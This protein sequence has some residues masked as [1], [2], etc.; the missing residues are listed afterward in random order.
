MSNELS[1]RIANLSPEK[2]AELLKKMAAQKAVAGN[3]AQG[4]IP[5]QDRSRPLPLSFAQQRL[6]FIDQLQPGT[7]L[8]NVPMAVRLE[9]A[10]DV[11]V[12]ERALRE[13]VRRHEVLRTTF[14]EDASGPVQVV[15]PEPV[16][17]LEHKDL[18]GSA[19]E[20]A[21][22]L[23][24][25][26]AA[27]PFD[28]AKG[29]LLRALLLTSAP[30]EHLLVVVVHH[31]ISDGWSMTLLVREVALLYGAFARGQAA[32]LPPLGIQYA[33]FGV[34][35]REWMQGPRLEKQLDYWKRQLAG[36]PSALELPTDFPRPANRDGRGAR[37]DVLLPRELTDALKALAQQEGASLY[38][39]LLTGWQVL[40]AR[41]SGQDDVTVGSPMAGR[42]RGEVEGLIGLFVN[43]QVLR[44]R[45]TGTASFRTL[46][47]Q[48]RETVLGAQ[49]HQELPIERLVEEVKPERIPGRTPFFQV[50]LTYQASF[51]GAAT[52]EGVKLEALELD[53]FSAKFDLTLQVLETDAG[54]KGY[55]EY[56][57][58]LFTASTAARMA[59][60]LRVLL[61]EAVAQ[62][63]A[64]VSSLQLLAGEERRQVLVEWNATRAPFPEA[65]MHSLFEAQVRRAPESVAAVFEGTQL[66]YAQLDARANQLAHALRRRG[67]SPE[68]RVALSVERSLDI[69]I[70]L[71]GIL[72]A[73]GAWVPVDPLL[74]R[75]RL[76]F[77]LEDSAAQVLVSQQPLVGRFPEALHARALCLDTERES[78]AK[79]PSDAP[80]TGVTPANMAYLLYTSGST[81]TPKGTAVEHRSV[82]NLVTH[83]AVAYGIGPGSR[84]LQFASLS[85]D[86][87]VEEIFT[88][89]CN[90]ATLVLAPLEKL[91]PGAPLPVL[92]REQELSV[93]SL[94]PAAL[95]ATSSE[96]LPQVRTV[97]S[98]GEALPADVVA[99]WAPGRRLLNTY[100]PTEATVIATFG[101]VV[102]DG[103]VPSIGKPLANVRVYVLDAH[104]Q[105]VPVGVRGEL[106]I[107][108]VGVARGYAGRPGLTA[109]RFV[110]DA[111]SGEEG[112][113]L[114]RTGDVVRWRADGQLDFVGR[115]DAQVKVRG[116]RIELGEVENALR[117]APA[118]KDA[119]VLAREDSPGD[120][121]LVAYVVGEALDVT[122]LRAHLKQHLPE[123]MVPA[124]FVPMD[125]LPLTSN[126]KVD[127]KSLPAPDASALRAS[128][129]YEAP[130]TPLEEKLA[131]LWSEVLRVPTVGRTDNFFE[132]G[133]HS[134]LATQLVARVRAALDVELPLRALFEAPTIEA[135]AERL[136]LTAA[137][138][139]LPPLIRIAHEG[140]PPLSF[141]QQRLWLLD[142]LQPGNAAYN[143][144]AALRLKGHVDLESLRRAFETL[145]ARHET[146]RTTFVQHQGQPAQRIHAP[147][148]W[149]LSLLDVSSLPEPQREEEARRL[150][151]QEAHRPFDLEAGPLLRTSLVRLGD[152]EHLL[153]VT[154]HHIVSDGWSMGVLV[155]ELTALYAAVHAAQAPTLAPL[156]VQYADFAV[157]QQGWLQGEALE[158]QLAYWKEKLAGAPATLEL[159]TDRPRP[160][161][162]SHRGATVEV[163]LALPV[164]ES[165][166]ALARQ[167]GATPFMLLLSAFQVLLSRYSGQDDISVGSPIAGRTQAETEGLIG[168]FV[169]T[170]VLRA[171]VAP[172]ATFRE[173]LAQ[174]RG[175]TLA[176]YEHQHLPFEKLVEVLQPVRDLSRSALFQAMFTLQ[177]APMDALRVPGLS[178]EQLPLESNSAKFDLSLTLQESPQGFMGVLEYSS[179][180]FDASTVQR[181]V[182]H[183]GVL[184]EAIAA[185][186]DATLAGLPLLTAPERRQ[187]LVD[188]TRTDAEFARDTCFHEAFTAQALRTPEA[189]A[190]ICRDQ[191]LTFR[192]LDTRAN[193]L[194]HRLVKLGVG[195]DVR[196]VLCVERS[197]E[198]LVGILG[199]LKA[200]GAYVPLDFRYPREWLAHVLSDTGAPVVL[201]QRRLRDVLPQHTAHVV[202][203]DPDAEEFASES[204]EAPG[205]AVS[206]EHLA[207]IIYTSGSTGRPKGVMI[208][209]RSV[210]NL[211]QGLASTVHQGRG[212]AERVSVNAPLS[213]DASVQQLVQVLD[214]HTLC[215]VPE[216]A[217]ADAGELVHRIGQDALEVLDCSP[218]HLRMLVDEGLLEKDFLPRRALVGGEAV[219][220]GTWS[221]LAQH[222]RLRAFNVYGPTECT[223]DATACAFDASPTPTIGRPLSNV[224]AYVL[225][226]TLR[227]VPV[228]VAG[229][230]LLGGEGVARGYLHRPDLTAERFIPDAF[231]A[232]PGAR[233]Y[234]TGDV[235]RWRADGMLDYLGRADFQVKVRG[236]RIELGEIEAALL[237]HPQVHAAVVLAREDSPGDKRL[238]AYVVPTEGTG[239]ALTADVLKDWLKQLLP[240]HMRPSTFLV[241]E[242]LPL[243]A[244]GKVDRKA[245]PAPQA[246]APESTYVAPRTPAEEQLTALFTQVLR[247]ERVGIHDDFFALG[248]H[249]L[250]ATQ[251]V[252]RVRSTFRVELPLRAL[253]EAPTVAALAEGLRARTPGLHLPSLTR[254]SASGPLP[255]SFAQQR[256]WFLDQLTPGD[257]SYNIPTALRLTG[258]VD[259]E[260]LRRAF[261]A[262]VA[263]HDS[264]R[265]TVHEVQGQAAQHV[266]A[267]ATWTLPL[268]D[269]SSLPDAQR[270][271]EAWR[272]VEEEA[273]QPFHLETG[274][275][276]RTALVRLAAEE[277]LLLVTMHHIISD[278]WSM[279]V[280]VRDLVAFYEAFSAG[281]TPALAPLPVQ[282]ADFAERQRQWLQGETL[283]TQLAYWKQQ[284]AGAPAALELPTDHPRPSI[285]SH[286]GTSLAV[287]IPRETSAALKALA[288]REGATPFMVLLAAWQLLLARYSGQDDVSV[289]SPIAGRTQAE[290]E[291]LIGFFVNTL[292]LRA[293]V[294][295]R[296]T[297]RELLAQVRGTTLAAYE[298]QHLPF[299]KLVEAVQPVRDA[300][301][302]PLFQVMFA[303]QNAPM[304][305]L[306]V[307][308]LTF[309]QV[310]AESRSAKFDLTLTLQDSPQGFVGWL[311]YSTALFKQGTVERMVSHL[312]TLL[313]ALAATPEQ[314]MA[315][316]QLLSREER[317]RL[318]VDWNDTT[319]PSPMDVPVHV[320]FSQQAQ[321]T[322]HA[323]ALVLGDDSLTYGQLDARANQLAHHLRSLGITPGARVGLAI[324][325]S[326]EMVTAL[327]AILKVGAAF[328]PVDRNAPV[329]RIAMLL[330]DADVGVVLTHQ[331]F[332][333]KLPA[334]GTRVWLDAQQDVLAALPTHAPDVPV[335]GESLAYVMFTSGS[336]GRPKGVSV[337]HRG[338]TRLVL[339][340]TFMRFGPDEVWLQAAPV[341]FDA[342]TLE[343]WGALL[344][345]AKLVLAPPH[346]LSLEE[347][348]EQ[349][350]RHR[351]TSLWLT[352]ALFEQMALHQGEALAE[353]RQVLTG[354]ELVPWARLRD[355]L[356]RLPEGV[357]LVHAYGPTENT[358]FSTTL[359]LH[360]SSVVDGP[361]SIGRPIPNS[362][363]YVLDAHLHPV[364]VGVA[365]EVFVGG[366]GLAWGYLHRPDLTAE[367]FVPHPFASTPGE[368]LYRTGDKARWKEDGTLD[369]LGRVDF[370][371][372]VRGF[373]IELGE[374]EA[375]LRAAPGV[376]EAVVIVRGADT[377]KRLVGYVTA[378]IGHALE[379]EG[380]KTHLRRHLPEYMVPSALGVLESLPLNVNGKVDRKA[381]PEPEDT[382]RATGFVAPRTATEAQLAALFAEVLRVERV[383]IHDDFFALGGH[384]LLATQLVSRVRATFAVEL[385]LRGFFEAPTVE[386]LAA[387]LDSAQSSGHRLPP[388]R[389]ASHEGAVPL[390]FAQQRLWFLDQL[391]P[392]DASYNI[393][394]ALRLTGR[395]D[396]ESLRRAFEA[397][398]ARHE[399]LR[400]TF[401]EH[402]GQATQHI[403]APGA[404]AL[405]LMD[406]SSLPEAQRESEARRRVAEDA[407]Q[408]F[409]LERGPLLRTALVRL[410]EEEHLLLV[411]MHHIVSD[412]WSMGVLVRELVTFY[413]AFTQGTA[414]ALSPLP[415]QYA[416]FAAWQR[417]WLQGETL[418]AQ[419]RYWKQQLAGAPVALELLTDHPRPSIQSHAGAALTVQLPAETTHALKALA[420]REGATPFMVLLAGFQL[421]LSRYAGQDDV[422]VGTPIAGRT[423]AETEGLIGFFVNTLVLRAQVNPRA[424]F[425]EL[426]AQVRGTTLSAYEHQHLPFEK[427]VEAVQ[428][429]RDASRSPLFQVMF[430][431]QNAPTGDLRVP[432]L[433]FRQV[434]AEARSA[435]FDLTLTLQDSPQ[436]FVG[437]LEY[438]TALFERST[439]ERMAS[440]LRTLL[441]AVATTP[442]QSMAGLP[443]LSRE[444]RQRILVD[445]NDTAAPSPM[446]VPVHVHFSQQ[447]QRTPHA[448]AL[449]LG[450]DSLT[451]G[452]LD[453]RANQLAHHLRS[454][455][456]TPGARVG[457]AIER[458]FEMVTALLAI[459]KAGAAFVPVDRNAPVERIAMLLEDADVGV[460]LTH[461]PFASKLPTSGTRVWLD[462][463]QDVLAAL[464]THAPD[465]PVEGE[466]LAY[467]MF[468]SGSTG[469]PKGVS[470]P[471]RGI[472]RLVLGSTF[473][474]F[475]PDEVWLQIAPI[476]FDASTLEL[477]GALLHG[478]KLVLTPPHALSLEELAEQLRRHRVTVLW[479]T[480]ALFEQ[481]A[482]HHGEALAEVRQVL[483]GGDVMPW[484]RLRDHLPRLTEGATLIHAYGPTENTTF[485][486][487]LPLHRGSVVDGPVSIGR[488]I[489]NSTAY[490]FDANLQPVPV[491]VAGEVYVGG[492]GLA[493]GYLHRPDLTAERFVPHPFAS[494]PGE[495]L[496]R[497]GDKARWREDG[498]LDFLGRVDF[499]VKVRG[500]RIELGEIEAALRAFPGVNEA[501]VV[502]RGSDADK[503]LIGYLSAHEGHALDVEALRVHLRQRLPE[504]M[505][506]ASLLVLEA[507][508][509]NANGKVDRKALPEPGDAPR[510]ASFVAPRT[511]TETQLAALFA[512]VLRVERVGIHDDF[513][514]LGGHSLLA[515]QLVSRVR[516]AFGVE[517]PL[518]ALFGAPTVE[519]LA[520][521]LEEAP[522]SALRAP[523]LRP[524]SRE[525]ALPLSFAQQ[526]LWLLDQLQPGDSSYNVP[527]ALRLSGRADVEALRRA[528]EALIARH[529]SLRTTLAA[530]HEAPSQ[531]VHPSTAWELP[532]ADL[533][534]LPQEQREE[535]A[536]RIVAEDARRPFQLATGPLLRGLL[537]RLGT[538]EHVLLV[539]MHHV[540]SDG[541]S[542]GVLVR[543]MAAFYEAFSTGSTPA[544]APLPVQYADFATWQRSWLQGEVLDAQLAYWKQRLAGAPAALELPTDHPRPP[545]QSHRG[546]TVEVRIPV[547]LVEA[548]KALAQ[549]EGAT[550]FMTLLAA[551][552]VLLSRYSAQDDISVGSPIAGR[553]QAET[554]GLIGFFV[555][556]LVLRAHV[557]PRSTFRE[558]LVQV[559]GTTLAAYDHQHLPF[560]KLVEAVQPTRDLSRNPLFQAMFVLQNMP[561]EELRLPGLS[562]R[563]LPLETRSAKFD[564]SLG[565]R[566]APTGIT[567]T[568]E[569]ATDLFDAATVQ[570]MAG[571]FGVLLEAIA[572]KPDTRLGDLPLLTDTERQQ[573]LVEWN[574][575]AS[576]ALSEPSIPA[577][578]EAQ[579]RRTPDALAIIT[580]ERQLTYREVDTKANQLA[581][582]LRG[583]GVGPEVRVGLCVERTEDLVIGA[584]GILKAGGAYVPLDPSYPRE[585]L[586]WLLE[587]AQGPALVAHSHLLS[588][589]PETS[590][591][592]VCLDSDAEL[593]RQPTT[594]P[595][596]DIH[597]GHLAY[598]IYTSGSTGRPKGVAISHGN[599]VAFLHWALE[600]FSPEELKGTLAATSL[601]FDLSVF[602]L[603]APLSSGG[604]VVVARN[605]LHLAELPTASHVTLVNTVPSAMAQLLRLG[606]VPPSVRVI[607]LAGEALPETLA[608]QVYAVPTVQKLFNLYGPSEDTTYST[609]SLV[610]RDE[611]PLIGRPLPATRAYVLDASLQPVPVG[612]A[613]ELYLAGE[614]QARGYLLRPELTAERF[615]PEPYGPPGGR[616]YRT[617]DRVRYRVDGRLEYLGRIDFQVKVRGF[618]IE[619][620]EIE[621][622]LR[623]APG[624]KEAVVVAKGE[625]ADKRLVAYV[626]PK[627]D[628]SLEAEA[629]RTHLRQGLPEYMVPTTFVVLEALPL[630]S[631][632][633]VDRKALPE[634][635]APQS[636]STYEAP[637]TEA[638]AKLASIWAEVLRLPQVGVKDSFFELGG[639]SLLAT[640]VVS[641]VRAEFNVE[642]PLRAL[643]ESSTVEALAG[644]LHGSTSA[645]APKFTRVT[646]DGPRPLSFAQQRLWLLDQLQPG[647]ASY[648]IPTALQLSGHLDVEALRRAFESLVQRHEALRTTFHEHQDQPIQTIHAASEWTLPLVDLSSRPEAQRQ[649]EA[650]RLANE[651]A[652]RPFDLARGPL[653]R[654]TLVRMGG[655]SHLLLLT[656]HH[657]ISDGWSM[658]VL[659][660]EMAAFYE[661]LSTGSTPALAPL[662]VQYADFATR[663][664][665]WLQGE[666]LEA[667][668]DYWKQQLSGAPAALELPTDRPRPP[669]QSH[670]GATVEVRIPE[671]VS[672]ALKALAQREGATPFMTLLAAFQVLLSRYSAQDDV[673]VGT[674]IAGRTQAETEGLIGFFVNTLVL[675]AQLNPRATFRELLA[676]VR[677][678]TFAAFEHQHVPFE[679]LVEVVQPARDLSRS[680]L[681]Q[682]LF[683]L[684]NTPTEALRLP[685]LAFQALPLEARFAKFDLSLALQ[686]VQAGLVGTL[687]YA[688]DLFD[689]ATVQRMAGHFGVLLEAIAKQP[690]TKL[691]DLPLL[692][693]TERRQLLVEWNP[694]A[695]PAIREPSIPAMVEAQVR[696][697]PDALAVITPERQ[698]TY[699]ELDAKANQLANRLR[700]LGVGPEVRVGLC[701]ERTEDLV[702]GALGILKAGGAYVPLDPSYPR[703]RLGWLLE[704]AQGPA[705]VAH[706]H[707]LSALP[708]TTATPVCLDADEELAKQPTTAPVVDIHAG[709]LAYLIYTSGSTGRPKGVAIS[710][711][712]AVSFLHW[713]LETFT[714]A[715]LK[716]TLAATSLNFDLSVFELFA[717]LS[718]G[719]AVVVA[720]NALH[721]AELP[722]ASHVTL[723]NTV[724]SAM[725]QLLRLG[726]VPPSVRVINLAGE[727]LPETLAKQV[728]AVPT[729]QKLFN[730][731]GPSED[732][733]YST[734]SLVGRDEVPL[735]G[736]PL[737][738]TRAYVLDA[739]LQPV[740]VGVA[741]ELY[742][743]GE[744]QARGY[745]LRP[746]LTAERFV[747]E[748][749][750]PSGGRMYRTGDRVRYRVDGRLEYLGRIDFQVKVRGFR[751]EL[752]E[753]EAA[754]RRAPGL[755]DAVVVAKGEAADKRLVAYVTPKA[756][757]SL[758]AEALR[759][760]LRQGLPEYMVPT[761]FV[762]LEA[763]PL[764]S[765]GKVDRKALPEPEAPQSGSTYEAPR[766]EVEAKL[767]A[768]W[769]EVLRLPQVG[770]KDSFF[771]LGG[772]S[773]LATQVVSRVRAE[774]GVELPLRAL[775]ESSTVEALAGR[776]H[777]STSPQAPKL[778]RTTHDG[779]LPLSFAQQRL[780]LL[781]QLQPED[782]SYN[783]PAA[784]QLSGHL[785]VEALRRAFAALVARHEAL[786]TTFH[787]H[788]GQPTQRIQ[789]PAEWTLPLMDLSSL[790]EDEREKEA[791]KLA[792]AEAR[793]PFRL[794]TGPLLRSALVRLREE[795]HLL[796]VTM[797]HIVSDGWSMGVLVRELISL[798]AAF[799]D[800]TVP[801]L[802]PLP[803]Q[804][805]DFAAWQRN[806]LQGE[807]LDAQ[808]RYWKQQLS[809]APAALELPTDRPRPPVQSHRGATVEVRI[810]ADVAHALKALAG[811]EGATPFMV[812]LAAF[813]LLLSRYSAQDDISV[814]SPIA[815]RT[816][817]ETEGLIGF[818][819]NT[820]VLRAQLNPRAT[821]RELLTQVRGTTFAAFEHQHLPFEKLVEAV[822]PTRDLSRSPLFQAMFVLQNTP[823]EVLRLPGLSFQSLPLEAHFAK[824]DL[825]L[826]LLEGRD[827]FVGTLEYATDLFDAATIQRMAG[828]FG[829]LLEAIATKPESRLGELPLLTNAERQQ[830][831][832]EWNPAAAQA[833]REPSIPAM[834]EAQ[835]RRTPDAL[836]VIT[837][838]RQLTY[839]ELDAKSN[840]LAHRLRGLGVGPEVRV[841][842][843]VERTE[844]LVIGAL[845][846][847]KAGG[848]YV[849][850]DPSYPRERLGWLLEDAQGPALV[851]HSHLLSA[852]PETT[853]T[854]VCLDSDAELAKQPT[855]APAVDI[856]PGHLAYLIYTSGSTGRPKGV[857]ISHGNA[858]AFLHWAL[859]TFSAEELKGTLAATSLN[860]DLSVFELFAPL[861]SGGAVV[862]A[863]NALHL[864]E[865]PTASHVTLVNTVPSAMAQLLRLGA[866]PPSVRVINLAGEA[867]PETLAKQVYAVPTVQKL[868][869]LYGPSED[870][871][872]STASLVGRDEVPLIGRPLPAT[873]A[874]VLDASLQ[875][876]PVGV[877]GELYL[878][879]EG[880]AR[881]YLLRPEL[882]AER[883]VPEPYG[884]PGGRMYRTGDR[885][886]YR[887]DGRLEYLGRIDFQVK[888]RGFRIELGEIEAALR[889]APGLKDAVVVAKGE[890][891]DKRLV[892]YVTARDGHSLDSEALKAHLRLQ[893]PEYM[894]PSA[895]LVLDALPL[896]SN[897]KVDRKGLPEPDAHVIEARDFVAPRDALEMQLARIWEDLL[898]VRSVGVRSS[899][900]ELGGHSLLAVRMLAS[901][902]ERL[903]LSLPLSVLFQQPTVEQ[904]AQVLRDDSQAWTPLVPLE[905][906][907]PGHRPLFLVHP[908]GGNVLAY[909]ELA[910]RL[911]PS[912][913][914]YGLQ[915]RGLD[916]RPVVESIEEMAAL[917]IEAVR[918]VQPQGPYQLGGW[919]LGGVIA[920]EMARRLREAGEAVELL[921]LI[922]AHAPGITPPSETEPHFSSEAR[923]R[924]AFAQTTATAFGQELSVSAE[925][926]AQGDD[927]AMLDHLLQEGVRARIL[928]AHSGAA[929]L[930][931]LFR[932]FQAN[933]FAQEKYVPRPYDGTALLLSAS[934]A[935]AELPRHRGWEPLVR[936]GLEVHDVPGSHHELLQDSHLAPIE[937]RLRQVLAREPPAPTES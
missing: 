821:F 74:P 778:T 900:F 713:A 179:D 134:L 366:P 630:N 672:R 799:H 733:T 841:G 427:L 682:A 369:F 636:G 164:S 480:T 676:Q 847:L 666:I 276:L 345:G 893:L 115:I 463:Q 332:A 431:L 370:Q 216:E 684:Q 581:N 288:G 619:L 320:H 519:A 364:P 862:V 52:V 359:P 756:D 395:V 884:P 678:T 625:A 909:S 131:A 191:Q 100:G 287:R 513:F 517:L 748:P 814:G 711:G 521:R 201:T 449:V 611:V 845:G 133:G 592:P 474:R 877:A 754:L 624:L 336:T 892:A 646:H 520:P 911:G 710:H 786:R 830:L 697:T 278:G 246:A 493:W 358:T 487:T 765:N 33:D 387:K 243:N 5:V 321:R 843:C 667:Q 608:K 616:M 409:H 846:I 78:L 112:A 178:F 559:R 80:V 831:L 610:G 811:R 408:P 396:V 61:Q 714:P 372:K 58:D 486:T 237:K 269:L 583:L 314:S 356:A 839:R 516:A 549:R 207:Y 323:V 59:E 613:G 767:A 318:L 793:R 757:A 654:S 165:L 454:L 505:V 596:A 571:H 500:F 197:V 282:Y 416:D 628:A 342:S 69:V 373:R 255:L 574:P 851:A 568:L 357:T 50:M 518:R 109:E 849:P 730:L 904:L 188:W 363:A 412:G 887:V 826:G 897:G 872:Y 423:Q 113:R 420:R 836:A 72:K 824:F 309:R 651:E 322:P 702:I 695:A 567:G 477:W 736:R 687:E 70:G 381:L 444:E 330:E 43:A 908:G 443:L 658:G 631:N 680:P 825:S 280:L 136:Q 337:P 469:R 27:Q 921:V 93:V 874:Y 388:L 300:S 690:D 545:V 866:V 930:R 685:G 673:S 499:Q 763:L 351:V 56:T 785:D 776:L 467:V 484:S 153:L 156:P 572:S 561:A 328:V 110:P 30:G 533:S 6:W 303:L 462:A 540:I 762:V 929:Q 857:A 32:P 55:L 106:H 448:V 634:P 916:G 182:G 560:E 244:N 497:T 267:P 9:G 842:L 647:D 95:A 777:G 823:N 128:H 802:T 727:A 350:R 650:R 621:A 899:F 215:I 865:L 146:L 206:A 924:I 601:N 639:H 747:P 638:E 173:L 525:G 152:A 331:P 769:A 20:E 54:L 438:S 223:V 709:H 795:S 652:R 257:A 468:T 41:Y 790:P 127:R 922:D 894:V 936:G 343:I 68:V 142:Q 640:Q 334:S 442:E 166:K 213:F 86:L 155:R 783:L 775:F 599:A 34:W 806:W 379:V 475:G 741:G 694:E 260:S 2:R 920:Y 39:A 883:F 810:P 108:G 352:T 633:K 882:T 247:V 283:E 101:E 193:Q 532:V 107:G 546:A 827:G 481:M 629:L 125:A 200:G 931:A 620:G 310:A 434:A 177:N 14:R 199:T 96:G 64:H 649:E 150:A 117:A 869:N 295:P 504:Y 172:R 48:V 82:A 531:R 873:R 663:Q 353:V 308:G 16:L 170:L 256:L 661:A 808:L 144:P 570:R 772:H 858:V 751:I 174:V 151:N 587:D 190:V 123:Y 854:P 250:L 208:Q 377:D 185:Q 523:P 688:T 266:H 147:S 701:V 564:L 835:V 453:A 418:D 643:F 159:P 547:P 298:H 719:G 740:P 498:T 558:L 362:T 749:Y 815:G 460:V 354:G 18:T 413:A 537:V 407:R 433:T 753:I 222:P 202:L 856:H 655:D 186:P 175:T 429:V 198:A 483:T 389:P 700:G 905:R 42:T 604:A 534:A 598:L 355:H 390:S 302:S 405:P 264:L 262:L 503:R 219:D 589:L 923:V 659:V 476:A 603:F 307:P 881:G 691:G 609:A 116:F 861:S 745:L 725:A 163:R 800:G 508:P 17:T 8:F 737:P 273:H 844:D 85:F 241:L 341:A 141:A 910:R 306:R 415:V 573:L 49:E 25:D 425:R 542:M 375:A 489:P 848:A 102:A 840:Q 464:P 494:T 681:F 286:A 618:R 401:Q 706:S 281:Q 926:L 210:M 593:A 794:A 833:T 585:R 194:A 750:G 575:P 226:K 791:R 555:N 233:L 550:P 183:L 541:W 699:R 231:S 422:S 89:L 157:W 457:L 622:A 914:V 615:V 510:A 728:Y 249:S 632:G 432:G 612:V 75:E 683:V 662:P 565:L 240:E 161:V 29:P 51:R 245:L 437:W 726:A 514:A 327:L 507:L 524:V 670:R 937:E 553:T 148:T 801:G 674:P 671:N 53:T 817:A 445:W 90:G 338:I 73:G 653:L 679:K 217:R 220:P 781:D 228:G 543:E 439:M 195:P 87:S 234:R 850:L 548:L 501:V 162:Q 145:V 421:L 492:P 739:S 562:M 502:A 696:R 346:A 424:T 272:K 586:G 455:G 495:R 214:G 648:N 367:R 132:L 242:S 771:E 822:Q 913:P 526:R 720:R 597:P 451:Y 7:S 414:P 138:T 365:G 901:I 704:D 798:Y 440:H 743:A 397:L 934:E 430:A 225:D 229:E 111:F 906:G 143:I 470:V 446:D 579:V 738:A 838:E 135:L 304:E 36:V 724:P 435:K 703:E 506:P 471:H 686:E 67:V 580:P 326:F 294:E 209:H 11:A 211:R 511:A 734:A 490:V 755:K 22:R 4:L 221:R 855:T 919:S 119:V 189:L 482:L 641:R 333:A 44:T 297:F 212:A 458:S 544:L 71:L 290:T 271:A 614:G 254:T 805:A 426:L 509:L 97:I 744:G 627:A 38:M 224:R 878:A 617:G 623:R 588:A 742:L 764:N 582:R 383:G 829:V 76:A 404:W 539:T 552:Q 13:V 576:Q 384:S 270:E 522:S 605:A 91:M 184:L 637:R 452:Q 868:F 275:L 65:C 88:T 529:E 488:P 898:G 339:G 139:R 723:V 316:L 860:F 436:G 315:G 886:R 584:L 312:R 374:I 204:R 104:G 478:A 279:G 461:Q 380:L 92:L 284:L 528:F 292:V 35:Q 121:R 311:E 10:L 15:S 79:E 512:E 406:V 761:T 735:I 645:Q 192:E 319:A 530:S 569:Y 361:V 187:L 181:M 578:V 664:R 410:G 459:L 834:V 84:V 716:G 816:Q 340:S 577:M 809:G 788:Q 154:M 296:A 105:P 698:L 118:V 566:E 235:V 239:S 417:Q 158:T 927:E 394:T 399:S 253:F 62:P 479:L 419:L 238:V 473:M 722:T 718:S 792:D 903:G 289:G 28:L 149:T 917:Y 933:L 813:Q 3:S 600:T 196:V 852:L 274:P 180:L 94:T 853:A 47:R 227:P 932:V 689:A 729:V 485:S 103:N 251:L 515:T 768:I 693:D 137:G 807:A 759:T 313:E 889:R 668:L 386:A 721:L 81:G 218:A 925:A 45:V 371:V 344:H 891:A 782:A 819:V 293:R 122:A 535:E 896:N 875:P 708:E 491:G 376:N 607:N 879:G 120:K 392:G 456:I 837:P 774:L 712:N 347:L 63:D 348:A 447:A 902:R 538:E 594:A 263:R 717:P 21:W 77:M 57:T 23:A 236:F 731:Y 669:V 252:S 40:M 591:T 779:P 787:E 114:Y 935:A 864:A 880:Q 780:W 259:V 675:R 677:G 301:R 169:N 466:S 732:T 863:R 867:L 797:H 258:P 820:L 299:E 657:I 746:E 895:L 126:G 556:T 527:T 758:E 871:T 368:R 205:V 832:V 715:E 400:T 335:E 760:H 803:V 325:R 472:T 888:V 602:E 752:G 277:H 804:Y 707:L 554:E 796:L 606:A 635:E 870:T 885:V 590:A 890:A 818:F 398:V 789:A 130:A 261:E 382:S 551:F 656:M 291:G 83:E 859:A 129:A 705:L 285:Q 98:G 60:H 46:L 329:E 411:T 317:Q 770:V 912:L 12:L 642:L 928:D 915:S 24:R 31:I 349:L 403:H 450:D 176:A 268:M 595:V 907:A 766:T 203:V 66:T 26:A 536:R 37:H 784:L 644:R 557:D 660:R 378:R 563:T 171:H 99:R 812:L 828:H 19:P 465:V 692:T 773:L 324:E 248:G 305:D 496:Y 626:T 402:Q 441:E 665:D 385:A 391:T 232:T 160:P 168:F 1:K 876:V 230:L 167:E 140:P 918:T 360:R 265:T 393:P 428:S 124:A